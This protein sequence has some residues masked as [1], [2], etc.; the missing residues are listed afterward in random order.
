LDGGDI[1]DIKTKLDMTK[2]ETLKLFG[3]CKVRAVWEDK[4]EKWY[5]SIVDVVWLLV[6]SKDYQI[7]RKYWNKLK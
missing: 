5:L 3:G 1:N 4:Q 6:E 7:V 2:M